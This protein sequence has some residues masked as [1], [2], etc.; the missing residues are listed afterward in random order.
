M[1]GENNVSSRKATLT[2]KISE[3]E[4]PPMQDMLII[5]R[6]APIGPEAVRRMAEALSPEQFTLIK[7]DHPKIEAVL[8]RNSLLQMIDE[9]LLMN[10]ILEEAER[11][12]SDSMVLRSELKIAISVQREVD[13][14]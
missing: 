4:V 14:L 6:K 5:G 11:M 12:I 1:I 8:L 13:L 2:L 3:F 9:K 7:M 10:I